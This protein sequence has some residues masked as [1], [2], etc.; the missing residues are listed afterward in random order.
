[1][2]IST[3][4][5]RV[6]FRELVEFAFVASNH[7][8]GNTGNWKDRRRRWKVHTNRSRMGAPSQVDLRANR[9]GYSGLLTAYNVCRNVLGLHLAHV[10]NICCR[11]QLAFTPVSQQQIKTPIHTQ[12]LVHLRWLQSKTHDCFSTRFL[13][14]SICAYYS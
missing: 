12:I 5:R 3:A 7:D 6:Q 2:E 8:T 4:K 13:L 14:V 10:I 11:I 9:A 1:M